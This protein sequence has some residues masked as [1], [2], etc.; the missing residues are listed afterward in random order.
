MFY[1]L[2]TPLF[3]EVMVKVDHSHH[4]RSLKRLSVP[5]FLIEPESHILNPNLL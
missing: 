3:Y 1:T 2:R 5:Q 4:L